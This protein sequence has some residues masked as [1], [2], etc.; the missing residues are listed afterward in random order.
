[1]TNRER[2][3]AILDGRS[4]DRVPWI[5]RLQVWHTARSL[6]GT[7]PARFVGRSLRQIEHELGM[8]TPARDG[9]VYRSHQGGDVEITTST[10]GDSVETVYRTPAGTVSTRHQQ[11]ALLRQAGIGSMEVE[12]LV[13]SPADLPVVEYLYRQTTYRAT[14][15]EYQ[16]YDAGIGPDGLPLVN[17]GDCPFHLFLQK[18]AGYQNGYYL[19]A[20]YPA[21]VERL[22][23]ALEELDRERVWPLLA[24]SP[25]RLILHGVHFDSSLTPPRLFERYI[26]PYYRDLSARLHQHGKALCMH[27]DNDSRLILAQIEAAGFDMAETFTTSPQVS[28]T[29]EQAR[30]AW[31]NRVIVW[32]GLPSV[33]L[34]PVFTEAAFESYMRAL[35]RTIAPGDAFILG[36]ADNVMPAARLERLE[37][38]T[39]MV[40]EWGAYPIDPAGVPTP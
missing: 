18:L 6:Q 38:V 37:R 14:Y 2:L 23:A 19:L 22:L 10:A 20:D 7:L 30:S 13:K 3:L 4:P 40:A 16:Q 32:G 33:L 28:C 29:L 27:A 9:Q 39:E 34:E 25:A 5:P 12:H 15:D 8:G 36:V 17:G 35:F 31:G 24:D 1:V 21:Q 26:T 11:S